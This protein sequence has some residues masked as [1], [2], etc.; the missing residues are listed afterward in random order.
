MK[1]VIKVS[2]T[3]KD[4]MKDV[5]TLSL[6][7]ELQNISNINIS[8]IVYQS[9]SIPQIDQL[10]RKISLLPSEYRNILFFRYCFNSTP[11]ET[12]KML[13]TE[14][15]IS[16]LRYVQKML[17]GFMELE[18]SWIDEKSMT[19]ACEIALA[20]DTKDYDNTIILHKSNYSKD[21]RL[22]LKDIS[23]KQ[24]PNN[25]LRLIFKRVAIFILVSILSFSTILVVN[26]EARENVLGWMI[27]T[28]P[29]FSIFTPQ[30]VDENKK[31][32]D[33]TSLKIKYIPMGFELSD[34][35]EGRKMLIYNYSTENDQELTIKLFYPS[36]EGKSYYDT[37]NSE[38]E[39][40][41]F[42]GSQA[43]TWQTDKMAY[44]IWNQDGVE[45]HISGD[46]NKD[47]ILKIAENI[48][49]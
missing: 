23:I 35:H 38:V 43:Y 28:F 24:K 7:D 9:L 1:R 33:L 42:K 2:K 44:L 3:A 46:L 13:G 16:K 14:N 10:A 48:S 36:G 25:M 17:S 11:S 26:A 41:I 6:E 12:N 15:S 34:I 30:V 4:I 20:E 49:K 19:K 40:I 22:K 32:V 31:S 27:E 39:E 18:G 21:F 37:E 29:K 47:E 5:C 45:C 8:G